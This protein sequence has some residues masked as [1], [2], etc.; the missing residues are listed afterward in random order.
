MRTTGPEALAVRKPSLASVTLRQTGIIQAWSGSDV[1]P[2][3]STPR[4]DSSIPPIRPANGRTGAESCSCNRRPRGRED[5]QRRS[6]SRWLRSRSRERRLVPLRQR[7]RGREF[8]SLRMGLFS[9]AARQNDRR[10]PARLCRSEQRCTLLTVA[11]SSR[12]SLQISRAVCCTVAFGVNRF[13][14]CRDR[15]AEFSHSTGCSQMHRHSSA[16]AHP[17]LGRSS[18]PPPE[19]GSN[20][21]AL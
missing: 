14:L 15:S 17:V 1:T 4:V 5:P 7:K 8:L 11:R 6:R 3:I 19:R 16:I 20:R 18:R 13:R 2:A 10:S 9:D 21:V 12:L